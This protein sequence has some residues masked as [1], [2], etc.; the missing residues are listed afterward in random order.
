MSSEEEVVGAGQDDFGTHQG[1]EGRREAQRAEVWAGVGRIEA[2]APAV[3]LEVGA[4][5][6]V[7][8]EAGFS[9]LLGHLAVPLRDEI[10]K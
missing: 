2:A 9:G 3:R 5:S 10:W 4:T 1:R 7:V 8:E 6:G